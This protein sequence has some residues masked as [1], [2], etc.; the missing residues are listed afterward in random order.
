MDTLSSLTSQC[1]SRKLNTA[2][3]H[4]KTNAE[5]ERLNTKTD[6]NHKKKTHDKAE[7]YER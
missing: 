3:D 7:K 2:A 6:H 5:T 4:G 1:N